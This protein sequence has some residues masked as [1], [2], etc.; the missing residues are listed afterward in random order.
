GDRAAVDDDVRRRRPR[1][2]RRDHLVA[3]TDADGDQRE[4]DRGGP[5]R[6]REHVARLEVLR[7]TALELG[8]ARAARKPARADGVRDGGDLL[9]ADGRGLERE[10]ALTPAGGTRARR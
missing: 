9:L 6:E 10:E 8:G 7:R 3:G 4:V 1:Q 2:R 5:G